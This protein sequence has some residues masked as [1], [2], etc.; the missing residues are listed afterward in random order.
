MLTSFIGPQVWQHSLLLFFS[1]FFSCCLFIEYS[2]PLTGWVI[3][4]S[5]SGWCPTE[6]SGVTPSGRERKCLC[7]DVCWLHLRV[8][9]FHSSEHNIAACRPVV[10][11]PVMV[12]GD[13]GDHASCAPSYPGTACNVMRVFSALHNADD[14]HDQLIWW[15]CSCK[16]VIIDHEN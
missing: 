13:S 11:R 7:N 1:K 16:L 15:K 3:A 14:V 5:A 9:W 6:Q 12:S 8:F 2:S 10:Y 4:P